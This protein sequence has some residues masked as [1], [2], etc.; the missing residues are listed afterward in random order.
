MIKASEL[1][2]GNWVQVNGAYTGDGFEIEGKQITGIMN[3]YVYLLGMLEI[4]TSFEELQPIPLTPEILEK[5][6]KTDKRFQLEFSI[7]EGRFWYLK[8]YELFYLHQLQ[9][10]YFALTGEELTV[11]L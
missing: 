8:H 6:G 3:N 2:I 9:N 10:L 5:C 1:R 7:M 4:T 11:N